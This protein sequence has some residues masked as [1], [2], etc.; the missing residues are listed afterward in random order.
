MTS[1]KSFRG[2][3]L[4]TVFF[5]GDKRQPEI[6]LSSL[7]N[8]S[9]NTESFVL[10]DFPFNQEFRQILNYRN[11]LGMFREIPDILRRTLN[12]TDIPTYTSQFCSPFQKCCSIHYWKCPKTK[13]RIFHR[14]ENSLNRLKK[15]C[16]CDWSR[17]VIQD[18]I[19][20]SIGMDAIG[21]Y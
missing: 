17:R 1:Q 3:S 15:N 21:K 11:F 14:I 6:G 7:A 19:H 18:S 9:L 2:S 8:H 12:R 10:P 5:S 16:C 20:Q 4:Q 13:F